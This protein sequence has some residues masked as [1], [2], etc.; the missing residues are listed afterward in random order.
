MEIRTFD[1]LLEEA[2]KRGRKRLAVAFPE[3]VSL[4]AALLADEAGIASPVLVG[5]PDRIHELLEKS[6]VSPE[7]F[8]IEEAATPEEACSVAVAL[9]RDNKADIVLKGGAQTAQLLHAV[10]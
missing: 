4:H 5:I 8:A 6:G 7:S 1:Q 2:R 9:A 10:L 3:E